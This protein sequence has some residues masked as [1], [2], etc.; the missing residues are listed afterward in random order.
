MKTALIFQSSKAFGDRLF[1]TWMP[2]RLK[3]KYGYDKVY[4][5]SWKENASFWDNNPFVDGIV[6]L[7]DFTD[8]GTVKEV[9]DRWDKEYTKVFDVRWQVEGKYLKFNTDPGRPTVEEL[10]K[11]AEDVNYYNCY[12]GLGLENPDC[13]PDIY[14]SDKE[15]ERNKELRNGKRRILWQVEGSARNKKITY[16]PAYINYVID[17]YPKVE[18]WLAGGNKFPI[19]ALKEG[20]YD[21]RGINPREML[22]MVPMFDL[23]VGPETVISYRRPSE[24]PTQTQPLVYRGADGLGIEVTDQLVDA[25]PPL[26]AI[27]QT[28]L[29][30]LR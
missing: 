19:S 15:K 6:P 4:C 18:N 29:V 23:I 24:P 16:L 11:N 14:L 27:D 1:I 26:S 13:K 2:K 20:V 9:L 22:S 28:M 7:E 3:R 12:Q 25:L 17:T 21:I 30:V 10:R 8:K 5:A